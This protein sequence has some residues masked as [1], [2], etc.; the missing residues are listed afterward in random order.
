MAIRRC[1]FRPV[2]T[3]RPPTRAEL[4]GRADASWQTASV[5]ERARAA[6]AG[7]IAAAVWAVQEPLDRRVLRC[8]YSDVAIVG[9]AL[10]RGPRLAARRAGS[11]RDERRALRPRVQPSTSDRCPASVR[12]GW[13]SAWRS[14]S[15]SPSTPSATRRPPPPGP[16][17]ARDP[18]AAHEP[19][20]VRAGDL[21]A[22]GLRLR[23]RRAGPP[24]PLATSH[25]TDEPPRDRATRAAQ[26][27]AQRRS[28][29]RPV[30]A[31][32][33][34]A[35]D[36]LGSELPERARGKQAQQRMDC[37]GLARGEKVGRGAERVR[38]DQGVFARAT[39]APPRATWGSRRRVA[40]GTASPARR[41]GEPRAAGRRSGRRARRRPA[42]AGRGAGSHPR[43]VRKR[44]SAA[45][46]LRIVDGV[47][48]PDAP[49]VH[50]R[51]RR[52]LEAR[53][54][55]GDPAEAERE[56]VAE[57]RS[58]LEAARIGR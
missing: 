35:Q 47:D 13:H 34:A 33:M 31:L 22:C 29:L 28:R 38:D 32:A 46:S 16:R 6:G 49:V 26:C 57:A 17:H 9:K 36:V 19:A 48:Q 42:R 8:D 55:V 43:P 54:L 18:A 40:P 23:A 10:T 5:G 12:G 14:S 58:H 20:R 11:A 53:R 24:S 15:T 30:H 39:R 41:H 37:E 21:A 1:S 25:E 52:A 44:R 7:A 27:L 50:E 2:M 4:I 45:S 3:I 51:V 56:L